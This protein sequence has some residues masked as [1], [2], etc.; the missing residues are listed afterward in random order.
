MAIL[1]IIFGIVLGI[2]IIP[3]VLDLIFD[4][5]NSFVAPVV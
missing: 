3:G 4:A 5:F 1:D 2:L